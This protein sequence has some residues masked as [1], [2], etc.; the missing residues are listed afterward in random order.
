MN[1]IAPYTIL[2]GDPAFAELE[3]IHA[4]MAKKQFAKSAK[5]QKEKQAARRRLLRSDL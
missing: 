4:K 5:A 3:K 2:K 1:T